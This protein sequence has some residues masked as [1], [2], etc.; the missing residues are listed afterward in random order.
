MAGRVQWAPVYAAI[1]VRGAALG[2][3]GLDGP[4]GDGPL[5]AFLR[6]L[7]DSSDGAVIGAALAEGLLREFAP[8]RVSVYFATDGMLEERVHYGRSADSGEHALVPV[9]AAMPLTEVYRTGES[10]AWMVQRAAAQFPAVAGWVRMHPEAR[11]EE[12]LGVPVR[13]RGRVVGAMLVELPAHAPRSWRLKGLMEA[14]SAGLA[15]W[16]L[17]AS[18]AT[19][20]TPRTQRAK[21]A[22]VTARQR[23]VVDGIRRGRSNAEIAEKLGVSVGTVKA[24]LA[25]LYRNFG[26]S[27]RDEL[28]RL[29]PKRR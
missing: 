18:P 6:V 7:A 17:S 29:V 21:G 8:T 5:S 3:A 4:A 9:E 11:D 13:G 25:Q 12:V 19:R 14:A 1:V 10:G 28:P 26:V 23:D 24:D 2:D 22:T 15:L 16:W 20:T 27:D